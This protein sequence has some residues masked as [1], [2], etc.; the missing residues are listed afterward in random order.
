MAKK[1]DLAAL[2]GAEGFNLDTMQVREIALWEIDEN[3][4]NT[5][6]QQDIDEL[7][8]SIE[9]VGLQQPLVYR[10]RKTGGIC[11]SPGIDAAMRWHCSAGRLHPAS[12]HPRG[13]TRRSAR[14][15]FIGRT[16]WRAAVRG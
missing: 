1:F 15:S 10:R 8:E 12:C 7:A 16:P 4:H 13:W 5:Y 14:S 6:A 11:C 3:P 2:M 9:V